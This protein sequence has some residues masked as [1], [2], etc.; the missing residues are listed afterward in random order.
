MTFGNLTREIVNVYEAQILWG[1]GWLSFPVHE[2]EGGPAI[3]MELLRGF[4]LTVDALPQGP[5]EIEPIDLR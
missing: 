1:S 4:R 2:I 3:G 5:I